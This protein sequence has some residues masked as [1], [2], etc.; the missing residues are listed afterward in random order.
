[1]ERC[2]PVSYD[3]RKRLAS[4]FRSGAGRGGPACRLGAEILNA[5]YIRLGP[6]NHKISRRGVSTRLIPKEA[7]D[8]SAN[9]RGGQRFPPTR[10]ARPCRSN[11]NPHPAVR[12][13]PV[14]TNQNDAD[15]VFA[16]VEGACRW[17]RR[18]AHRDSEA[19]LR[20][21]RVI[22]FPVGP[23]VVVNQPRTPAGSP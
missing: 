1:V 5:M 20:V 7:G 8:T 16:E 2:S 17:W 15:V 19:D 14:S 11:G 3:E 9:L 6:S 12:I 10:T 22:R 23:G 21:R 18:R 13:S 4:I